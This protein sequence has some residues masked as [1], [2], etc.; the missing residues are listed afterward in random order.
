MLCVEVSLLF[1]QLVQHAAL[2]VVRRLDE[3]GRVS[4]RSEPVIG[5]F[6]NAIGL[7]ER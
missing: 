3:Y 6:L 5:F 1:S 2:V 4:R 7:G